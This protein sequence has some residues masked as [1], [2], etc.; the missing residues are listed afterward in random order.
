VSGACSLARTLAPSWTRVDDGLVTVEG[1]STARAVELLEREDALATLQGALRSVLDAGEGRLVLVCGEAGVGKT[2]LVERFCSEVGRD[3]R[4]LTGACDSLFTPRPLGAIVELAQTTGGELERVVTGPTTAHGVALELIAELEATRTVLVLEDAHW[5]DQATLDVLRLLGRR[6]SQ[7]PALVLATYRNEVD[8]RHPLRTVLGELATSSD[9]LRLSLHPLSREAVDRIAA[10]HDLDGGAL[11]GLTGGNPF[12]VREVVDGSPGG[13]PPTVRDAVLARVGRLGEGAQDTLDLVAL[14]HPETEFWLVE[15]HGS[16]AELDEC[17]EAGLLYATRDAVAFRH[18]LAQRA[19]EESLS[20]GRRLE[21]HRSVLRT[22]E[23]APQTSSDLARLAHHAEGAHDGDAVLRYAPAAA[24]RAAGLGAHREAAAQYARA[25]RYGKRMDDIARAATHVRHSVECYLTADEENG[26]TSIDAAL[27]TFKRVG[28]ASTIGS[29][30]RW[31]ALALLNWGLAPEADRAARE[32]VAVLEHEPPGHELA[33][34][35][36]VLASLASLDER[37]DEARVHAGTALELA[38]QV[39]S[40]EARVA[41]LASTG[42]AEGI[43]GRS[44]CWHRLDAAFELA[45]E[46]NLEN[47]VGRTYVFMAMAAARERSLQRMG[48]A[49]SEGLAYT[50]ERDLTVWDDVLLAMRAWLE[51]EGS[52]WNAAATTVTQVLARNC[53]LSSAQARIVLGLLRARRGD[54]DATEPLQAAAAVADRSGQLWWTFQVAAARAETAWLEG[55]P[56]AVAE[57]TDAVF[58]TVRERRA[59]WPL[60]ELAFWRRNAGIDED[61]PVEARGPF[62]TQLRGDWKLAADEWAR[63]GCPYQAALALADGD[64]AAQ[65]TALG[66]LTRLG[67]RPAARIVARR[68]RREGARDVP[69]APRRSTQ[70]NAAGLTARENEV[71]RLVGQGL[72][73]VEIAERLVLSHRTVDHHVSA[74]LRKLDARTRGEALAIAGRRGLLEPR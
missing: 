34:T 16:L 33:M 3:A 46:S 24:E 71:L 40:V 13:I 41:A 66:E 62:A 17:L 47:Q 68:L 12:F 32:A 27:N 4:V 57:A 11:Y 35:Y 45:R 43:Q 15:A 26:V 20:P 36:T 53:T 19:V 5:G 37:P 21:L 72:R 1:A 64:E 18:E 58:A 60:A 30:L 9:V 51:L 69:A 49:L 6:I 42:L 7:V 74:I 29:T 28:D 48:R 8:R 22:L 73:N 52:D 56:R 2:A 25:L 61:V 31:R 59:S 67:A 10:D 14:G 70:A 38:E 65:R 55:R 50:Y 44:E 63:A 39:G 54:P 23:Q